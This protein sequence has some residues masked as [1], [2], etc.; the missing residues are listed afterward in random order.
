MRNT[1]VFT[2]LLTTIFVSLNS[3]SKLKDMWNDAFDFSGV[4]TTEDGWFV[5]LDG[6]SEGIITAKGASRNSNFQI[7]VTYLKNMT[8]THYNEW[9][10][11]ARD[12][13]GTW[14]SDVT[15][16]MNDSG[17]KFKTKSGTQN[18]L[19]L[20]VL[21][22][23]GSGTGGTG[24]TGSTGSIGGTVSTLLS[25]TDLKGAKD[26]KQTISFTVPTG[27]KKMEITLSEGTYGYQM[28]DMFVRKGS[29]PLITRANYANSGWTADCAGIQ[30]NRETEQC[31]FSNPGSDTWYVTIYG[32]WEYY[33]ADLTVKITK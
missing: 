13:D 30:P 11:M 22:N 8:R 24:G 14:E 18:F 6:S 27:V 16:T 10:G 1:I 19:K 21:G 9:N 4:Y 29:A 5:E 23:G 31:V 20:S 25:K 26:S 33:G 28:A 15:V 12:L 17:L 32:Y 2:L 7:G 3:C